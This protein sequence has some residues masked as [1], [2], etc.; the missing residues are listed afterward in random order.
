MKNTNP[1]EVGISRIFNVD[2]SL[3]R[4]N[5]RA[6]KTRGK[7]VKCYFNNMF[8]KCPKHIGFISGLLNLIE[9]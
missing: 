7:Y 2:I 9:R 1:S 3:V 8:L 4:C 6:C 5:Y